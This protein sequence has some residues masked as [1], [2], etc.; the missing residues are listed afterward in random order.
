[1]VSVPV[2]VT[3]VTGPRRLLVAA[4][5]EFRDGCTTDDIE[6]I[7]DE[8]ERRL[9][10]RF[11]GIEYVFLD[12]HPRSD[13]SRERGSEHRVRTGSADGAKGL[14]GAAIR[15]VLDP[16]VRTGAGARPGD[17]GRPGAATRRA[18]DARR[19]PGRLDDDCGHGDRGRDSP[20]SSARIRGA[21]TVRVSRAVEAPLVHVWEVLVSPAGAAGAARSRARS[22]GGKGEPYHCADGTSGCRPQLPPPGT[23][24][25]VLAP[26][27]RQPADHR[28]AGPAADGDGST[29]LE[30]SQDHLWHGVDVDDL[31]R[32]W[33]AGLERLA[34]LAESST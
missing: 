16:P 4:K 12:R 22:L 3:S 1:M 7:A 14:C 15:S 8:A 31:V 19:R 10:A 21:P 34:Q 26:D 11:A 33:S 6:R 17:R 9:V 28:G 29:R 5:V 24:P 23:A 32:R 20:G 2:F 30:L 13:A 27:A 18:I 25:G